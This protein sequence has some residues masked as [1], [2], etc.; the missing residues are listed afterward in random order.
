LTNRGWTVVKLAVTLCA[1]FVVNAQVPV[2]EQVAEL[3]PANEDPAAGVALRLTVVPIGKLAEQVEPQSMPAGELVIVPAP[4]PAGEIVTGFEGGGAGPK[5]AVTLKFEL[6]VTTHEPVPEHAPLQPLNTDPEAGV[7]ARLTEVPE[8]YVDEQVAPQM[9]P[10][11][12]LVT[13]PV[14][15]PAG[16]TDSV[17]SW[18]KFAVMDV[19]A[20]IVTVQVPVPVHGEPLQPVNA[21][22]AAGVAVNVTLV[23]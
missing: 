13:V 3:Q 12:E 18:A 8:E 6:M 14:P 9:M 22:P 11:R 2:P 1:E 21:K 20:L 7:A 16:V 5:V 23:P 17:K 15:V 10:A 4:E 19:F